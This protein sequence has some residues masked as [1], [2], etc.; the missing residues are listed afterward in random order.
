MHACLTVECITSGLHLCLFLLLGLTPPPRVLPSA[1]ARAPT[2]RVPQV[3]DCLEAVAAA[4]FKHRYAWTRAR[5]RGRDTGAA[6]LCSGAA[7]AHGP[8]A[9]TRRVPVG[10]GAGR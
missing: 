7:P 2:L 3:Y 8:C 10:P 1:V 6:Q 4:L 5:A 9:S